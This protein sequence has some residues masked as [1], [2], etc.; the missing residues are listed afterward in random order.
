MCSVLTQLSRS[1][2]NAPRLLVFLLKGALV[3]FENII[4][5]EPRNF[6]G[7]N[8][9]RNTPTYKVAQYNIACCYSMLGQVRSWVQHVTCYGLCGGLLVVNKHGM[10]QQGLS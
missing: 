3:E 6:V 4:A 7:D 10:H 1:W 2:R 8:F 9:S 5:M